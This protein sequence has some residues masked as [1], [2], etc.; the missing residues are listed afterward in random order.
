MRLK[1]KVCIITGSGNGMG[2]A[3]A[4]LFAR[5]GA[6]VVVADFNENAGRQTVDEIKKEG[7]IAEFVRVD[8][9]KE[10]EVKAMVKFAVDTFGKL[11]VLFN[12]AGISSR[13]IGDSGKIATVP[14]EAFDQQIAV[15]LKGVFLG[16]KHAIPEMLKNGKGSIINT[17][18]TAGII[19][20]QGIGPFGAKNPTPGPA[21]YSAAKGGI[22][23]MSKSIGIAYG[24]NNIRCNVIVPGPVETDLMKPLHLDQKEIRD[25]YEAAIPLRRL[26]EPEDIAKAA[27]FLASD[28]SSWITGQVLAVDGGISTY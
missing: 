7:L 8:V 1:D 26:G 10:D 4:L 28:E 2:K 20:G 23:P 5:E 13:P 11:D 27:I 17:S 25:S 14:E 6:K 9:S 16:C 19:G 15:N 22:I 3:A 21:A 18:S 12:N 24:E